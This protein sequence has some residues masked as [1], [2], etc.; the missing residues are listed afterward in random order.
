MWRVN[1][2]VAGYSHSARNLTHLTVLGAGHMVPATQ[3]VNS[4]D[5]FSRFL[6]NIPFDK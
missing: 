3:P 4:L 6:N 5:M 1:G 2:A